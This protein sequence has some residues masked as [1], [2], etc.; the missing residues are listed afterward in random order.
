M[1]DILTKKDFFVFKRNSREVW[2]L[3][4]WLAGCG[5]Q[6]GGQAG[7]ELRVVDV[8]VRVKEVVT[9]GLDDET[10]LS[11]WFKALK[12]REFN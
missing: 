3:L 8:E 11:C 12:V 4:G 10:G 1:S 5:R 2:S 9:K 6:A 7:L